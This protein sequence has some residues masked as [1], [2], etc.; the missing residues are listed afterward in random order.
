MQ[1]SQ[2]MHLVYKIRIALQKERM[3]GWKHFK[4]VCLEFLFVFCFQVLFLLLFRKDCLMLTGDGEL[5]L[6]ESE[7]EVVVD[8]V[9]C[10]V[11]AFNIA[12]GDP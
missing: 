9:W 4:C 6:A 1:A 2:N 5:N 3:Q 10:F 7:V 12:F 8:L 11:K